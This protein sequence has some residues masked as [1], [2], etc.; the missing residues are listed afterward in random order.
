MRRLFVRHVA[1]F[2]LGAYHP[3]DGLE[4]A[5]KF[6]DRAIELHD[7]VIQVGDELVLVGDFRFDAQQALFVEF[8]RKTLVPSC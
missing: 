1:P 6:A 5:R 4:A 2:E 8:H 3:L 7:H